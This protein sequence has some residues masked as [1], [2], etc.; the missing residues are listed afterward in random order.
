MIAKDEQP[1]ARLLLSLLTLAASVP[2]LADWRETLN[3][4]VGVTEVSREIHALHMTIFWIC[5]AIGVVVFS[6]MIY[7]LIAHRKSRGHQAAHFHESTAVEIAWTVVPALILIAMAVPATKAMIKL[8]DTSD[9]DLDVL[10]TGYQWKWQYEYLGHG[11][12]FMS[13]LATPESQIYGAEE[14]SEH[15]LQ[16][17]NNPLVIPVGAKVRFLLTAKDVIHAWWVPAFGVKK[18][19]IPGFVNETWA[20]VE[21]PGTYRGECAELCGR[22]HAFM[23]IVVKAVPQAEF[24]QWLAAKKREAE[25]LK[26]LTAK[27]F[28]MEELMARGEEVYNRSC[29]ACHQVNGE[30]IPGIF[31][32]MKG[33]TIATGPLSGHLDIVVNGK[34]GT[35]MQAFGQQLSEVDLAAVITYERNAFGNDTGDVVQPLD[36]YNFKQGQ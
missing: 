21:V 6:V 25:E 19:A 30:G 3:M 14:K 29:A 27:T 20:R 23:P 13:E 1:R 32:P 36:V 8:Y 26:A 33:S 7:S 11:V 34:P 16:E 10:V 12:S 22:G 4:P 31:P 28:T 9:A 2:A 24:D 35:A 18:D 5:V 17:V 15:Y